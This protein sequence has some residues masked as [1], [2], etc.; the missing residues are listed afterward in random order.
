MRKGLL[1]FVVLVALSGLVVGVAAAAGAFSAEEEEVSPGVAQQ[2]SS[3]ALAAT[4]GGQVREVE[5]E[6]DEG[7]AVAYEVTIV[8][9]DGSTVE[10]LL[11]PNFRVTHIE[12][13]SEA[14]PHEEEEQAR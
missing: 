7:D 10:V 9:P 14:Q 6:T 13:E 8:K 5:H 3:A 12:N 2:A 4:G 11:D 1:T